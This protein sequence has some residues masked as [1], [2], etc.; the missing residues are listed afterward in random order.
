MIATI[1]LL[2]MA[3]SV[4]GCVYLCVFDRLNNNIPFDPLPTIV[5]SKINN[6]IYLRHGRGSIVKHWSI[7]RDQEL[8]KSGNDFKIGDQIVVDGDSIGYNIRLFN[9]DRLL[10][11]GFFS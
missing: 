6:T 2:A 8:I 11:Y 3:I 9:E 7:F 10:F 4:F 5:G 1:L